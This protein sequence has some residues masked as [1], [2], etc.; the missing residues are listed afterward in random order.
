MIIVATC[1]A[2]ILRLTKWV[3]DDVII[4]HDR[5]MLVI[6]PLIMVAVSAAKGSSEFMQ[7]YLVKVVGQRILTDLQKLMYEHLLKSDLAL[8][9]SHSSGRLIS[10]FSNDISLMRAAVS[11]IL[12]GVAKHLF[13]VTFVLGVMISLDPI[14]FVLCFGVFPIAVYPIQKLGKRMRKIAFA[15]QEELGNYTA[16]LDETFSSIKIVKSYQ[17]EEIES[18]KASTKTEKIYELYKK[19]AKFDSLASPIM[20]IFSGLA[21]AVLLWYGGYSIITERITPGVLVAFLSSFFSAYRPYKSLLTLNVHLQEGLAAAKRL[22]QI[23]DTVPGV[24]DKDHAKDIKINNSEIKFENAGLAFRERHAL[25]DVNFVIKPK[26]SIAIVGKSGSGKTSL[27]NLL[28]R[29]Y[30]LSDGHIVIG[31][32][33][34]TDFTLKSLRSQISLVTQDTMLFDASVAENIAY[35][36]NASLKAIK[37]AARKAH[38]D[39]FIDQL[40]SGYDTMIGSK[41]NELSGGQKQRIAIARAFLKNSPILILDEATSSLDSESIKAIEDSLKEL[42]KNKTTIIVTHKLASITDVDN[43]IVLKKG[44]LAEQGNHKSLIKKKGEYYKLFT[45]EEENA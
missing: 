7:S 45:R 5:Q 10:R 3:V 35:G 27:V 2:I 44:S 19:A 33:D 25:A 21:I 16:T 29:F 18:K 8:I 4:N 14:M 20:E 24:K 12:V 15:A 40:P 32:H 26:S 22:F 13:T 28:V 37:E 9:E 42:R 17:A 38:A 30:D 31:K 43:I 34:I 1:N 23:L 39:E 11:Q 36:T 41:G 6:I